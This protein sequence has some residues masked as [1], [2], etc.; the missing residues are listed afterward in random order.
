MPP[1]RRLTISLVAIIWPE[2][3]WKAWRRHC[4]AWQPQ[5]RSSFSESAGGDWEIRFT[6]P[7]RTSPGDRFDKLSRRG[8]DEALGGFGGARD[9]CRKPAARNPGNRTPAGWAHH[10]RLL[11]DPYGTGRRYRRDAPRRPLDPA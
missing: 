6:K 11:P 5:E 2:G 4:T 3:I 9:V 1:T 8:S 7:T 10:Q